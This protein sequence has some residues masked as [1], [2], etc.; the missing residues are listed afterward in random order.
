M[1]KYGRVVIGIFA[2]FG[3]AYSVMLA[4]AFF[5]HPGAATFCL[6]YDVMEV[7]SPTR[8]YQA[9]IK[10]SSCSAPHE[11]ELQTAVFVS[12]NGDQSSQ[13]VFIAPS[14]MAEAG[15]YSPMPLRVTWLGDA[16]LEVAYPR[17]VKMQSRVDRVGNV[18]L[19][20]KEFAASKP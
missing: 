1:S 17:G 12:A 15:S 8:A 16:E 20:Y 5:V 14:A 13:S 18:K 3:F 19:V 6:S 4:A 9:T 7:P 10:N 2:V 11:H